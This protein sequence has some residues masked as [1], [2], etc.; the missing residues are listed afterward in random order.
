MILLTGK[1][2]KTVTSNINTSYNSQVKKL[3]HSTFLKEDKRL[4][5]LFLYASNEEFRLLRMH[6]EFCAADTTFGTNNEKKEL[7]TL[8]FKDGNNKAFN[9]GRC[10]IPNAQRWIFGLMFRHCLPKFWGVHICDKVRLLITDGCTQE[11]LPFLLKIGFDKTFP[12]AVHG[13]CYFHLA[14]LGFQKHVSP[15]VPKIGKIATSSQ[16]VIKIVKL[17]IKQWFFEVEDEEEYNYSTSKFYAWLNEEKGK[18]FLLLY[19]IILYIISIYIYYFSDKN[20]PDYTVNHIIT[21]IK[22]SLIPLEYLWV[23]YVRLQ[24][25]GLSARTTSIGEALHWATK[26]SFDGVK[27]SMNLTNSA[28]TLM[29]NAERKGKN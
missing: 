27:C 8:A 7:F 16:K 13:L 5:V 4:L 26:G 29:N 28:N 19:N 11:Y 1:Q 12:N 23:N 25:P 14:I 24:V 3:Y 6:P 10:F 18:S 2:R 21:W 9:G 15:S 17:W 20:I 22:T